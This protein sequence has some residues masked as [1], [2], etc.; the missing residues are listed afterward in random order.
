[1]VD[2][3]F[4][5]DNT[6]KQQQE[7]LYSIEIEMPNSRHGMDNALKDLKSFLVTALKRKE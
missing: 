7:V 4:F 3:S 5:V 1:M 6:T 2:S